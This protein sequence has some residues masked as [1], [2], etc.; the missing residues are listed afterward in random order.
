M[1]SAMSQ[2]LLPGVSTGVDR[3]QIVKTTGVVSLRQHLYTLGT[4]PYIDTLYPP[5]RVF[6]IFVKEG[7]TIYRQRANLRSLP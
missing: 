7:K 4:I 2:A 5:N 1:E 6:Y 3:E